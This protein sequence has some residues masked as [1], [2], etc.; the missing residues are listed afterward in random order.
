MIHLTCTQEEFTPPEYSSVRWLERDAD[1]ELARE[2]CA[3]CKQDLSYSEWVEAHDLGYTYAGII[4]EGK[5]ISC[6]A[7]WRYSEQAWEV[8]AVVTRDGYRRRG[9]SKQVIA[10]VTAHILEQ[11]RRPTCTT[12]DDNIAMIATARSVG[13]RVALE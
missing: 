2:L 8:A 1:Y 5:L 11:G 10:F 12:N 3:A 6:A 13:F 9:Y 7:V 4:E